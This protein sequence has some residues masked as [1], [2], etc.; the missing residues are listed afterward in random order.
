MS[1]TVVVIDE[2][3]D[4]FGASLASLVNYKTAVAL[5]YEWASR[6]EVLELTITRMQSDV[7]LFTLKNYVTHF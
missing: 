5:E 3:P 6:A 4:Y 7:I 1:V 2:R